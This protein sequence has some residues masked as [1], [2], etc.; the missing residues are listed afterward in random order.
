MCEINYDAKLTQI[1]H[2]DITH[3]KEMKYREVCIKPEGTGQTLF[4]NEIIQANYSQ[5]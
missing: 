1:T 4:P 3:G 5:V 2:I